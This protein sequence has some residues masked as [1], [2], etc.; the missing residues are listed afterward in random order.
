MKTKLVLCSIAFSLAAAVAASNSHSVT[1]NNPIWVGTTQLK[2]GD[3]KV[4]VSGDKAV[5]TM[6]KKVVAEAPA[7]LDTA[8]AKKYNGTQ[9]VSSDSKITEID[10]GGTTSKIVFNAGSAN[11]TK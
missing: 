1:I 7:S 2:P 11:G 6:N 4:E 8:A 3:Y 9:V 10:L 5:F